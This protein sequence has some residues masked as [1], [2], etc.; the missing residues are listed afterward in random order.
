MSKG[1]VE[2]KNSKTSKVFLYLCV[3]G[4]TLL[5]LSRSVDFY[6]V[7]FFGAVFELLW[8]PMLV[9]IFVIP[10]FSFIFWRTENYNIRSL[11]TIPI[12]ILLASI[13][14]IYFTS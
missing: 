3:A 4:F 6:Q 9:I 7:A 8:L 13:V 1:D 14:L 5:L 10:I 11:H 12:L 2:F